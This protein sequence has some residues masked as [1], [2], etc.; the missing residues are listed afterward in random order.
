MMGRPNCAAINGMPRSRHHDVH[1]ARR[2]RVRQRVTARS[3]KSAWHYLQVLDRSRV[4]V[5][6]QAIIGGYPVVIGE[7]RNSCE[8]RGAARVR[9]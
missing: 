7:S 9:G 5:F 4:G 6:S 8:V 3:S 1:V 2:R